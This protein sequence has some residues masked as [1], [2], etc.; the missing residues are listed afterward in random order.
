MGGF[1]VSSIQVYLRLL[2]FIDC[3]HTDRL[4]SGSRLGADHIQPVWTLGRE[5][6]ST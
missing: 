2:T 6:G 5:N 3:L 4:W 1:I